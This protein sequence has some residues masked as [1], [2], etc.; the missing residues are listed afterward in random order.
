MLQ[1]IFIA[2]V[3]TMDKHSFQTELGRQVRQ[4]RKAQELSQEQLAEMADLHPT[5][6]SNIERGKV[7]VSAFCLYK[8]ADALGMRVVD[9]FPNLNSTVGNQEFENGL[10][11]ILNKIRK[12]E[13]NKR[14]LIISA[15]KGML[16]QEAEVK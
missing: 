1:H 5:F 2:Y 12:L 15:V 16:H 4:Y 7:N 10:L 6:I 14:D 11:L 8:I 3:A 13:H 9:F